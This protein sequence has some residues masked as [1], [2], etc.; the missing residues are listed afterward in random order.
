MSTAPPATAWPLTQATVGP[1][2]SNSWRITASS[3]A[4]KTRAAAASSAST[5][6]R[7]S[8]ALSASPRPVISTG[9]P[10][11]A[12]SWALSEPISALLIA[13]LPGPSRVMVTSIHGGKPSIA[14]DCA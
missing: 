10:A 8:P 4:M 7:S 11:A 14:D 5:S 1:G 6:L 3:R 9:R 13:F 12:P 2:Y